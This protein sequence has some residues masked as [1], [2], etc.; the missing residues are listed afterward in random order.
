MTCFMT[1]VLANQ[2]SPSPA[3]LST[4]NSSGNGTVDS[5]NL[6][7]SY[8]DLHDKLVSRP[9]RA[10]LVVDSSGNMKVVLKVDDA[11]QTM[12]TTVYLRLWWT[13]HALAWNTS[14]YGGVDRMELLP[15]Q[16]WI[17][18]IFCYNSV[19]VIVSPDGVVY[20][21]TV[22]NVE[23][24]CDMYI[25]HFPYD[26]QAC[27][28]FLAAQ[29]KLVHWDILDDTISYVNKGVNQGNS[30]VIEEV[31]SYLW[32]DTTIGE[33][34]AAFQ[35]RLRRKSTFYTWCLVFPLAMASYMNTLVFLLPPEC[36]EK[37][38]FIV[39]LFVSA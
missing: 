20:A 13:D 38:S 19:I 15:S 1:C 18:D 11:V 27:P 6:V 3:A 7:Q 25:D 10:P 5:A 34:L 21:R 39:T 2:T 16:I 31:S 37:V 12:T 22:L 9:H 32:V 17:P 33:S 24:T 29:S 36:G 26:T 30:W 35:V 8:W 14:D 28:I 4:N 23:S